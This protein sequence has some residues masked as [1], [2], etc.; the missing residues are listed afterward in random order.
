MPGIILLPDGWTSAD[1]VLFTPKVTNYTTNVYTGKAWQALEGSGAVFLPA[2]GTR[3]GSNMNY[4]GS[5]GYYWS[6]TPYDTYYTYYFY[7]D[8]GFIYAQNSYYRSSG[9]SVRLVR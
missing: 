1:D 3:Y 9:Q 2:A 8:S 6:S 4:V 5:Y 7:F